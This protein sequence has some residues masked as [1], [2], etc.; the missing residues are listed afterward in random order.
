MFKNKA[1][2]INS[3]YA[4]LIVNL[5]DEFDTIYIISEEVSGNDLALKYIFFNNFA[6]ANLENANFKDADLRYAG[7]YLAF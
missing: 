2:L 5:F 7:F 4:D 1:S 6:S 3:S